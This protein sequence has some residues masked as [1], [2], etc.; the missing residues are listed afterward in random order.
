MFRVC[1]DDWLEGEKLP[2]MT[3]LQFPTNESFKTKVS[4]LP[5]NGV[6]FLFWSRALI[7]SF[8]ARSDLLISAPSKRVYLF[9]STTSAPLSLPAKSMNDNLPWS[10]LWSFK[11]IWRMACDLDESLLA[12]FDAVTLTELPY[13]ITFIIY[14]TE[15][16]FLSWRPTML[17]FPFASSLGWRTARSFSRSKSLPQ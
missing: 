7:H 11:W 16:T 13:S 8:R 14:S 12:L 15:L 2:I 6:W 10:L 5:L 17:T 1:S 9:W 3:V 4:L